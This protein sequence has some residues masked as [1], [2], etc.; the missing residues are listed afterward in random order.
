MF[1][2][3]F[4]REDVMEFLTR[5]LARLDDGV[6]APRLRAVV[7]ALSRAEDLGQLLIQTDCFLWRHT[8]IF[9]QLCWY[10]RGRLHDVVTAHPPLGGSSSGAEIW[11]LESV[12]QG[13]QSGLAA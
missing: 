11:R 7:I 4:D 10:W 2:A 12:A 6:P 9:E 3:E 1:F 8:Q 5:W 13:G